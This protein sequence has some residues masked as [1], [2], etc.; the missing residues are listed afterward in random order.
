[1]KS[2]L[3]VG[4]VRIFAL[5]VAFVAVLLLVGVLMHIKLRALLRN[6]VE[7]QVAAQS[8]VLAQVTENQMESELEKLEYISGMME[9]KEDSMGTLFE[10]VRN[11]NKD[12]AFGILQL[13]GETIYGDVMDMTGFSCTK[14]AFRGNSA[15]S[16]KE[17]SGML[18]AVPV[19]H[20]G[21]VKYVLYQ[22]V[23]DEKLSE[24]FEISFYGGKGK[25]LL[26]TVEGELVI[27]YEVWNEQEVAFLRSEVVR[28]SFSE[29]SEKMMIATEAASA[30]SKPR[31]D[32]IVSVKKIPN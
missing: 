23:E 29:I 10:M 2:R 18:F 25:V 3:H 11:E 7:R 9:N 6:H 28:N 1:M 26:A 5:L 27:P 30:R 32:A 16:Y 8:K 12:G 20:N 19:Y 14:E 15:I 24:L 4:K 22:F 17:G 13:G 21:N 31:I